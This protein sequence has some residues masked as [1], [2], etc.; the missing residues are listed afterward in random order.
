MKARHNFVCGISAVIFILAFIFIACDGGPG[1]EPQAG[2]AYCTIAWNLNGGTAA[3]AYPA[4]I[5]KGAVLAEPSPYPK[6]ADNAFGGWYAD[7]GLTRAYNFANPVTENLNLHAKWLRQTYTVD[8]HANGGYHNLSPITVAGGGITLPG[9]YDLYRDGH[10]FGGWNTH[11]HGTGTYYAP[12]EFFTPEGNIT[13]YAVWVEYETETYTVAF[14]ANGG[15]GQ[16]LYPM[17]VEI[18]CGIELPGE[19]DLYRDGYLFA[20]WNT[21]PYGAG[22]Y[23]APGESFTPEG[24]ITLYAVWDM[25]PQ[26]VSRDRIVY[27]WVDQHGSLVSTN[28]GAATVAQGGTLAITSQDAGYTVLQWRLNG[29]NTGESGITYNFSSQTIGKHTVG[30]FVEKDG[31]FYNTSITVTVV[32]AGY[33]VTFN[34]NGATSGTAPNPQYVNF[35][36]S[37]YIPWSGLS[38]SGYAFGGWNTNSDGTGYNYQYGDYLTP[39]RD[40]TLYARWIMTRT[41]IIDMYDSYG[42]GWD[43]GGALRINKNGV[44]F[45]ADVRVSSG[46]ANTYTFSVTTGDLVQLYWVAGT[47]QSENSFIAYYSGTPPSPAFTSSNNSTWSGS[48]ALAYRLRGAM[49]NISGGTLLGSFT[50]Q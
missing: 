7:S 18:D 14:N 19:Y 12:G 8:F 50:V 3:G 27:Y 20:G 5:A 17:I 16:N 45:A 31:R 35:G 11:P 30:V 47:A 26:A 36:Y 22:D 44:Q 4:R 9:E 29:I 39:E 2:E 43:S 10:A 6:K 13:L 41:V 46:Y 28:G 34:A 1:P 15:Y 25:A 48:N 38:R 24:N 40:I 23:Y 32:P 33:T 42:D 49:N 37:T 21:D